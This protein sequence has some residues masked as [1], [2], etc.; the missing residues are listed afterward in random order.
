MLTLL[1]VVAQLAPLGRPIVGTDG[2]LVIDVTTPASLQAILDTAAPGSTIQL[3]AGQTYGSVRIRPAA[4]RARRLTLTTKGWAAD[5]LVRPED[6][7]ALATIQAG[8]GGNYG[9][10]VTAD[11]VTLQ[12]L[13]F[14]YNPPSGQGDMLRLGD[15]E[16]PVV[17]NVPARVTV[18][19]VL[20]EGNPGNAFGQKRAIAANAQDTLID[21]VWCQNI[22][23]AGQ[24][25]QCVAIASTPGRVTVRRSVLSAGSETIIIG[26][27][28]PASP[29]HLPADILIE[30]NVLWKPTAWLGA[31]PARQVKNLFEVKFGRRITVRR[32]WMENHWQQAQPGWSVVLTMATNGACSFC[33]M[34][35]VVFEDNVVWNV[36]AG[37]NLTGYQYS[38]APGS[39]QAVRFMVRNNLFYIT[40]GGGTALGGNGRPVQMLSEPANVVFD[41][42][43][44]I[45]TGT[46]IVYGTYGAKWPYQ[47]PPLTSN[48]PAGPVQGFVWT[49]NVH[50]H[51]N[52]G[53]LT[54][55]GSSGVNALTYFPGAVV[56]GNVFGGASS[57]AMARYNALDGD[58]NFN[59]SLV[60]FEA[61]FRNFAALDFCIVAGPFVGKG[62]DCARLPFALRPLVP[63]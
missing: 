17:A 61:S 42:N 43:T 5:R 9:L 30:D 13:R 53:I 47:T 25:S 48:V 11:D 56:G 39:G 37:I 23:I 59:P 46:A 51:A 14:S 54:P 38:Y 58:L 6:A 20:F 32:N 24:D 62:A 10:W 63:R 1:L 40:G 7:P 29:A 16:D 22:W 31:S 27:V 45:H 33:D 18:R 44:F 26:G 8:P 49:N 34:Q 21:Q 19:Q 60:D 57:T 55:E 12:G 52:Y 3:Q 28:P 4:L 36:S 35:D 41:R 15:S 50:R 2:G